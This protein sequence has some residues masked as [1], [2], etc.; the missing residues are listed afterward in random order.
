MARLAEGAGKNAPTLTFKGDK[1]NN[2]GTYNDKTN[3]NGY[4]FGQQAHIIRDYV[5]NAVTGQ[6]GNLLKI[7]WLLLSTEQGY[8]VSQKW[9]MDS[10]G[11]EKSKYYQARQELCDMGWLIYD[12]EKGQLGIDY[13]FLWHQATLPKEQRINVLAR[14]QKR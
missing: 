9:V 4:Y 13:D 10:T 6:Q 14:R 1:F 8:G 3:P 7:M 2:K 11:L 5:C 12:E